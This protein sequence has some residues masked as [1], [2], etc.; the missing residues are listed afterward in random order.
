MPKR[1]STTASGSDSPPPKASK[2]SRDTQLSSSSKSSTKA[3]NKLVGGFRDRVKVKSGVMNYIFKPKEAAAYNYGELEV[4]K[5]WPARLISCMKI[6]PSGSPAYLPGQSVHFSV[7]VPANC[8]MKFSKEV[9]CGV[10]GMIMDTVPAAGEAPAEERLHPLRLAAAAAADGDDDGEDE[11]EGEDDGGELDFDPLH[12]FVL[13]NPSGT[14]LPFVEKIELM[15][16]N[17]VVK[18]IELGGGALQRYTGLANRTAKPKYGPDMTASEVNYN[19]PQTDADV[20][21]ENPSKATRKKCRAL[22]RDKYQR[23]IGRSPVYGFPFSYDPVAKQINKKPDLDSYYFA[24]GTH[25]EVRVYLASSFT[26]GLRSLDA[27]N[28]A[29]TN[30]ERQDLWARR[31]RMKLESL[32][33]QMDR[34]CFPPNSPFLKSLEAEFTKQG[35]RDI[36]CTDSN[37]LRTP[38][39]ARMSEQTWSINLHQLGYPTCCYIF[40]STNDQID[41]ANGHSVNASCWKFPPNLES[42]D[43]TYQQTS[44]LPGGQLTKLDLPG[45]DTADKLMFYEHQK[46]FRRVPGPYEQFFDESLGQYVVLDLSTLYLQDHKLTELDHIMLSLKFNNNLSPEGYQ[47]GLQAVTEKKAVLKPSGEHGIVNAAGKPQI[48]G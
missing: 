6:P 29:L 48:Q 20:S 24:P 14:I 8:Y 13:E 16:Q 11:S 28:P 42:L 40:F 17:Q 22:R 36:P 43:V 26:R 5:D 41:G 33:L 4:E 19:L 12:K 25:V 47:I 34:Q 9:L 32:W 38:L 18:C 35:S 46:Q 31:P 23:F 37:E 15:I 39:Y 3:K 45:T 10:V 44:L 2:A 21:Y 27:G 30:A 7:V 1:A